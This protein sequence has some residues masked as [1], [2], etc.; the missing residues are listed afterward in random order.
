[1]GW[2]LLDSGALYR[3]VALGR[4]RTSVALDDED[5]LARLATHL[6]ARFDVVCDDDVS[7]QRRRSST[8]SLAIRDESV[9]IAASR[10]AALPPVRAALLRTQHAFRHAPGLVADGRDMGTVV[11]PDAPLKIFLDASAEAAGRASL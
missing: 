9:S 5:A 1:M 7:C 3:A 4:T 10:V 11:F 6:R 8:S 2:H